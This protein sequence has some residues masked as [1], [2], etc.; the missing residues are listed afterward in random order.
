[1]SNKYKYWLLAIFLV[2]VVTRLFLAFYIPNF[3]Y[4]SYFHLRQVEHITEH[5]VPLFIDTLSYGGRELQI[6][7]AFHYLMA[8]FNLLM[9]LELLAKIIPNLL[10]ASLTL[11]VYIISLKTTNNHN[12]SLLSAF[13][14]GFLPI[15]FNTN[16]FTP[17]TLFL[18]LTFMTIYAF[19]NIKEK[20]YLFIYIFCFLLLSFT[21]SATVLLLV[22]LGIYL[23][24]SLME[25]KKIN[26]AELELTLFSLFFFT[27][28]QFLFFKNTLLK[29]G[30][31][32][33]WQNVPSKIINE[34]FPQFS[35]PAA[36]IM[37]S[38]IPFLTGI[39]FVY[40]SLFQLKNK[41]TF[42]LISF[43]ISTALLTWLRLIAFKH[44]LAFFGIILAI[45]FAPF[46]HDMIES[47]KKT[48]IFHLRKH[49]TLLII[50]LLLLTTAYPAISTS[51]NQEI[52][53]KEEI[54][55]FKWL[56]DNTPKNTKV[57][58]SLAEGHLVTYY[59]KRKN[60]MDD[61]FGTNKD[62][63]ER[64]SNLNYLFTTPFETQAVEIFNEYGIYYIVLTPYAK[65]KYEI[66]KLKYKTL[67]CFAVVYKNETMIYQVKCALQETR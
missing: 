5:G 36:L 6:L 15:S 23:I 52:P 35:I 45:L 18:P 51:L 21:S 40:R 33:I 22:G 60:L 11:I 42:L 41:K 8:L 30:L 56:K 38:I 48:K 16:S 54:S 28:A 7:P 63:E 57:A 43:A 47:L 24:L 14:A 59:G 67:K 17:E 65:E 25:G 2:T 34:Y 12:A 53:S 61:Q 58:A 46:Y 4:E 19:T 26:P 55:A 3:T 32:F 66:E 20:K 10:L 64:F 9:P 1:M 50:I 29:Q 62:V 39:F 31:S 37:V 49:I 44:S 13:V 27:W